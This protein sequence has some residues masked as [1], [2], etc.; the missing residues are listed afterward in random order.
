MSFPVTAGHLS[1]PSGM[2][3]SS[4]QRTIALSGTPARWAASR[5]LGVSRWAG[6]CQ[7]LGSG[8]NSP[9]ISPANRRE[10]NVTARS[11]A[12]PALVLRH[13]QPEP[14]WPIRRVRSARPERTRL[15]GIALVVTGTVLLLAVS[16]PLPALNVKL[17]GLILIIAWL[18]NV[19]VL[20]RASTWLWR[21]GQEAVAARALRHDRPAGANQLVGGRLTVTVIVPAY[22]EE[23]GIRDTLDALLRQTD[24]PERIVVV[25]DDCSQDNTGRVAREYGSYGVLYAVAGLCAIIGAFAV[26]PVKGVR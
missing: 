16:S 19:R 24:R 7:R 2:F 4:R 1:Q 14:V 13:G 20:Q 22:N 5:T 9:A 10:R 17:L 25:V 18:I 11:L 21:N 3:D 23:D 15:A 6:T 8:G 12:G 26:L